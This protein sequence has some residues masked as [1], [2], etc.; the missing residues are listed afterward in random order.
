MQTL[1]D[2]YVKTLELLKANKSEEASQEFLQNF[3][4]T[5]KKL[6]SETE[7]MYPPK[8]SK[9]TDWCSWVKQLY[10]LTLTTEKVLKK[11]EIENV[12]KAL[13][14]IRDHFYNLHF[15]TKTEKSN[16][17]I[18]LINIKSNKDDVDVK[19]LKSILKQLE[20]AELSAKAK[21]N[22]EDYKKAKSEWLS[23]VNEL[24][25]DDKVASDELASLRQ[26][27]E[28]FYNEFGIQFE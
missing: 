25:G 5:V 27:T 18:Y 8:F 23:K 4:T 14:L 10:R 28:K 11:N 3:V 20:K 2:S 19:D 21:A 7:N 6:F 24:L 9:I 26:V 22:E 15:E 1:S 13:L 16:D 17:F 12:N